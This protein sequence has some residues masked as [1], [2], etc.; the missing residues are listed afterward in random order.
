MLCN[1]L[2]VFSY[3]QIFSYFIFTHFLHIFHTIVTYKFMEDAKYDLFLCLAASV[4]I[5][6]IDTP[7]LTITKAAYC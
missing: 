1:F 2:H 6:F 7:Y 3:V 5:D 4:Q